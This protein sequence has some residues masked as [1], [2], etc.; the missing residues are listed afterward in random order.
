MI[1]ILV[2]DDHP[3]LGLG[4]KTALEQEAD[5]EAD[6]VVESDKVIE[7]LNDKRYDLYLIDLF[8]PKL[9][10]TELTKAI[11]KKDPEALV[12][13]YTGYEL[14]VHYNLILDAGAVGFVSKTASQ[15]QLVTAIRCA[16]RE[17]VVIPISLLKQLRRIDTVSIKDDSSKETLAI[18]LP[19]RE[20]YILK[21]VGEG[22][23]NTAIAE[24]LNVSQR[25]IE[26]D[27][28]RIFGKLGVSS[29]I[30]AYTKAREYGLL[31]LE[32]IE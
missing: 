2:V 28:T 6:V 1:K 4:T 14:T 10:G 9:N 7:L 11:L 19:E 23:K 3:T 21:Q 5:I 18:T 20:Q 22:S 29:R 17:E 31:S 26:A 16:L 12:L 25:T 30:E 24:S 27:L 32:E 8:M 15:E 13:I